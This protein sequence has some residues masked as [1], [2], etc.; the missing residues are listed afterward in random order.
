V[1]SV[2]YFIEGG[3]GDYLI[4]TAL[5][6]PLKQQGYQIRVIARH[7]GGN[8]LENHPLIDHLFVFPADTNFD[9]HQMSIVIDTALRCKADRILNNAY[10]DVS[11]LHATPGHILSRLCQHHGFPPNE[12]LSLHLSAEELAWG[13]TFK[14][15]IL[16]QP[17]TSTS[18]YKRWPLGN[19]ERL[20]QRIKGELG[21]RILQVRGHDNLSVPGIEN[22]NAPTLKH[23]I[24]AQKH[25]RLFIGHDSL[26][27]HASQAIG[28]PALILWHSTDAFLQGYKQNINM[29][30]G[31]S[32]QQVS[33]SEQPVLLYCQ[34]CHLDYDKINAG[35]VCCNRSTPNADNTEPLPACVA[36]NTVDSVFQAVS[37]FLS[38][39]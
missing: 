23:A 39:P 37:E 11:S 38:R 17:D 12:L 20:C 3:L 32:S 35:Q 27:N 36:N 13:E 18:P 29:V 14:D 4:A 9:Y 30:N 2:N 15:S 1:K 16:I 21:L 25:A 31:L 24:A 34:P 26:F 5:L 8:L 19:W 10:W 7:P 28:K 22:L 6:P 33:L